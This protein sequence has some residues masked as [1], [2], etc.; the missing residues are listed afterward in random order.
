MKCFRE[1]VPQQRS[2]DQVWVYLQQECPM[3]TKLNLK[4]YPNVFNWTMT[5]RLKLRTVYT[6]HSLRYF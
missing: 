4:D 6:I 5:Y 1:E 3:Y 2:I